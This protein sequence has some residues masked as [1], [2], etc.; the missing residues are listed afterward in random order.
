MKKIV[1]YYLLFLIFFT[2]SSCQIKNPSLDNEKK[3]SSLLVNGED[4]ICHTDLYDSKLW[5][6]NNLDKMPLPDPHVYEENG[7]YY[8]V[9]TSGF[10]ITCYSTTDFNT[11]KNE[12]IIYN[13]RLYNGWENSYQALFA[14][15]LYCFDGVYYLYYSAMDDNHVRRNSVVYSDNIL[16]P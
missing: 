5:Y 4:Y 1:V 7:T 2:L 8:I 12:G 14:P 9:G 16:G 11:Y 13:P 10:Y 3:E 15:E 6:M